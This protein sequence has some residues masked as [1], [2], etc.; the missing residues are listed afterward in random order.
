[1]IFQKFCKNFSLK[2]EEISLEQLLTAREERAFLQQECLEKYQQTLLSVT[3]TAVGGVKKNELLDYIFVRCLE[4]LSALFKRLNISPT[5][6]FIRPLVTG[7]E[8]IFVLPV[9]AIVLKKACIDLE[10]SSPLARLWDIDV[11]APNGE[12]LSRTALGFSPRSCLC[13]AENAKLCARSRKHSIEQI[14]AQMQQ[15]AEDDFFAQQIAEAVY[16][17]LLQ[18]VYLTPKPGLVDRRN[19]GSHKDMNVQTFERSALALRP[20]FAKFVLK[21]IETST[22]PESQILTTI[23]PLGIAAENAMLEVTNGVNTHKGAIFAFGLICC[24]IG[25]LYSIHTP[26][27][28]ELSQLFDMVSEFAKGLTA[29]LQNYPENLPLTH[30]VKLYRAYG[31]TGARGEAENGLNTVAHC[32]AQFGS[33]E[34]PNLHQILLWLMAHN[35]DTNVVHRGGMDGLT[36]VKQQADEIL[37]NAVTKSEMI[38]ALEK[39]DNECIRRNISCGG[40]ADLLALMIFFLC[41][42]G[43]EYS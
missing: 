37:R 33:Q 32:L 26:N 3:L 34:Q 30:G 41:I 24:A 5:A 39:L 12:L 22:L 2:G 40:S 18:E 16:Q 13:C 7:H 23:R 15:R 4:H 8:A 21:G 38:S 11:V 43:I 20:F 19:N 9:D 1:M 27:R 35:D 10:D 14:V 36:F 6:E 29:E 42:K 17:S 28:V 31:L 25:R